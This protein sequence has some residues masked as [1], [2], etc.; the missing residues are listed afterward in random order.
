M[1]LDVM[2]ASSYQNNVSH[3]SNVQESN[4]SAKIDEV[5]G[6]IGNDLDKNIKPIDDQNNNKHNDTQV[7]EE[8]IK[9]EISKA[10]SRLKSHNTK[11]EFGYHQETNRVTIKIMDKETSEVIREVPPEQTLEMIQKM[12]ELAGLLIDERR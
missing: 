11:C 12:W 7:S 4:I 2:K 8:Q 5:F 10:N 3:H 1:A 6:S 9:S